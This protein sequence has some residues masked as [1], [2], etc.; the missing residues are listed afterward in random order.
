MVSDLD[1]DF[2]ITHH[3]VKTAKSILDAENA[4]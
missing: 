4:R 2:E 3:H 1:P